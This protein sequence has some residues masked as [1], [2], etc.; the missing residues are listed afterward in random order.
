MP[1]K[2]WTKSFGH[3]AIIVRRKTRGPATVSFAVVL[4]AYVAGKWI[5]ITRYDTEHSIP[6][7]DVLGAK[8]GLRYKRWMDDISVNEAFE[9]AIRDCTENAA[10]YLQDYLAH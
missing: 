5:D 7:R 1:E 8:Q 3:F 6:H 10:S 4:V 9:Y 2:Q